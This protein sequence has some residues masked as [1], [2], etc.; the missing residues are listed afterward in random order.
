MRVSDDDR[1]CRGNF[2]Y[3][4]LSAVANSDDARRHVLAEQMA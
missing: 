3:V 1:M 2:Y 4:R